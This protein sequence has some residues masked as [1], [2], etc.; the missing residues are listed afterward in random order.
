MKTTMKTLA[1]LALTVAMMTA[2]PAQQTEIR[3]RRFSIKVGPS[4]FFMGGQTFEGGAAGVAFMP[5]PKQQVALEIGVGF[6]KNDKVGSFSY[7]V[8]AGPGEGQTYHDGVISYGYDYSGAMLSW[9]WLFDLSDKWQMHVGPVIGDVMIDGVDGYSTER[10]IKVMSLPDPES[11]SESMFFGG[12]VAGFRWNF[13][14]R[15]YMDFNY[16]GGGGKGI[17]FADR[18]LWVGTGLE[19]IAGRDFGKMAH[20]ID[21]TVGWKLGK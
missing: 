4:A 17:R 21:I 19:T 13:H 14:E 7:E 11:V 1:A 10:D 9:S 8:I 16:F 5:T 18:T 20:R 6:G 12:L 2:A 15:A 3:H